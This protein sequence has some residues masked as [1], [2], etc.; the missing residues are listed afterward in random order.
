[1]ENQTR[2]MTEAEANLGSEVLVDNLK[3]VTLFDNIPTFVPGK[4][5]FD[6]DTPVRGG[7]YVKSRMVESAKLTAGSR[8][9]HIFEDVRQQQK[10]GIWGVGQLDAVCES[11]SG[12][13]VLEITYMGQA[14]EPLK[15]GQNPPHQFT[16]RGVASNGSPLELDLTE[17]K[18]R[19]E[20]EAIQ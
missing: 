3:E 16:F 7:R 20:T 19:A 4:P 1:M 17:R 8:Y 12:G 6:L 9:L 11:L 13:D 14:T 2:D 5:G 10:F 18:E 15:P